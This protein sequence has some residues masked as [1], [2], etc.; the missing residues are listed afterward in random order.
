MSEF[1]SIDSDRKREVI[2]EI[3]EIL[4]GIPEILFAYVHGSFLKGRFRDVDVAV[5]LSGRHDRKS[6]L[7][8]ELKLEELL[9]RKIGYPVDVRA[10]NHA[11][12]S[13]RFNVM[14]YGELILSRDE[15]LRSDFEAM[16]ISEY[17]DF[18]HFRRVYMREALGIEVQS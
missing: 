4:R 18:A 15:N 1:F 10:L 17:H 5:Y 13:F 7:K 11:P 9:E 8:K 3:G 14:R 16:T 6:I 2:R 12:L